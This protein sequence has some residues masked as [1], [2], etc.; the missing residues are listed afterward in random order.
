MEVLKLSKFK[1][2]LRALVTEA[3][4]LRDREQSATEQLHALI[5]KQKQNDE[6]HGRKLQEL[7]V[8]LAS[9]AEMRQKIEREMNRLRDDNALL[10]NR[11]KELKA[12]IQ[13]LLQSRDD[14][15]NAYR[16]STCEMRHSVET[17]DR[18]LSLLSEKLN[19]HIMLFD[20]IEKEALS[21]K[22][23]MDSVKGL[24]SHKEELVSSLKSKVNEVC[25]YEKLF[26]EK[27]NYLEDKVKNDKE[28]LKRKDGVIAQL[29][30]QLEA[31]KISNGHQT[32]MEEI[33]TI[34]LFHS[35]Q[36]L[37]CSFILRYLLGFKLFLHLKVFVTVVFI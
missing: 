11:Q 20:S 23:V 31:A 2:Q 37:I 21:I 3:R 27:I 12:T 19:S 25:A 1:L 32:Q 7:Q 34:C 14:F 28:E 16:E 18:K 17:R 35:S 30:E 5:Q 6:D 9:S 10:E 13:N 29:E 36:N 22:Q 33:S 15:I 24:I 8:E 4:D 26:I